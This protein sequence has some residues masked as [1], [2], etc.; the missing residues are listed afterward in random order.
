MKNSRTETRSIELVGRLETASIGV[1]PI[2]I[3]TLA[4]EDFRMTVDAELGDRLGPMLGRVVFAR[5]EG[6]GNPP[7]KR[8][9]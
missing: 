2:R 1:D 9:G 3:E 8:Q 6:N 4:G 5:A 7:R